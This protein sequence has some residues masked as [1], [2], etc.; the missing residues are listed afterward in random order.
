MSG[1]YCTVD[2]THGY[3]QK[4]LSVWMLAPMKDMEPWV[5]GVG[6]AGRGEGEG[7]TGLARPPTHRSCKPTRVIVL[8]GMDAVTLVCFRRDSSLMASWL[9][10]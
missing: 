2:Y 7:D 6:G 8:R 10:E 5:V 3:G 9:L 1:L 4:T